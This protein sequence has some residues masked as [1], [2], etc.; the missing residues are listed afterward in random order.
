MFA[1]LVILNNKSVLLL[2]TFV[3]AASF[4]EGYLYRF[5]FCT[6]NSH[7]FVRLLRNKYILMP[8]NG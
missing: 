8:D 5:P 1:E 4:G 3:E 2:R 6:E 7:E